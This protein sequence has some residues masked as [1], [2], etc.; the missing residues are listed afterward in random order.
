MAKETRIERLPLGVRVMRPWSL[1]EQC[2]SGRQEALLRLDQTKHATR[3]SAIQGLHTSFSAQ[4]VLTQCPLHVY[5]V[6]KKFC[7]GR[8]LSPTSNA[9]AR[10]QRHVQ[11]PTA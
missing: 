8:K 7:C 6:A 11:P 9:A 10:L 3:I 4:N 2:R 1:P 5:S